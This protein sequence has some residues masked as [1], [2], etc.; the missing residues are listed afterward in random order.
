[1]MNILITAGVE[2]A[3]ETF[4]QEAHSKPDANEFIFAYKITIINHNSFPVQLLNRH[5]KITHADRGVEHVNGEGVVGRQPVL[6]SNDSFEYVSG[7]NMRT[8]LGKME[9]E[10]TFENKVNNVLFEVSIPVFNLTAPFI[11]N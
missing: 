8:P 7:T 2:I 1:M 4:Y 9:G 3:V 11:L 10:Y 5:W 6:Y